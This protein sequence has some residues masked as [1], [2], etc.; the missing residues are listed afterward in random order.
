MAGDEQTRIRM[1]AVETVTANYEGHVVPIGE[2]V[3][4]ADFLVRYVETG[5]TAP[6]A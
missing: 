2:I 6:D 5:K 1:W 4:E 3:A